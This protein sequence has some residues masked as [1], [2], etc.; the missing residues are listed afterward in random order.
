MRANLPREFDLLEFLESIG[1]ENVEDGLDEIRFSCPFPAHQHGDRH[2]SAYMNRRSGLFFCHSCKEKGDLYKFYSKYAGVS[3]MESMRVLN[4]KIF[5]NYW[6]PDSLQ[7]ELDELFKDSK[8]LDRG[9]QEIANRLDDL[10]VQA[11]TYLYARGFEPRT[12]EY[13]D[14]RYDPYT[15]RIAIPVRNHLDKLVGYKARSF[16]GEKPKYIV[17]GGEGYGFNRYKVSNIVFG[18]EKVADDELVLVEGE[19]DCIKL[20][21]HNIKN[22]VAIGSNIS[23]FQAQKIVDK[24]KQVTIFMDDDDAG[25]AAT[26]KIYQVLSEHMPVR[27]VGPHLGDP[28]SIPGPAVAR[29]LAA[30]ERLDP[31]W[32]VMA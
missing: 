22:S 11:L 25:R 26:D 30:A 10:P 12:V 2:P 21:Q 17:L 27:A 13:W 20:W 23:K 3:L 7:T 18:L 32:K 14:I 19:L 28:A 9:E 1:I 15:G 16:N 29:L 6:A 31:L 5:S 4:E 24:A 8:L